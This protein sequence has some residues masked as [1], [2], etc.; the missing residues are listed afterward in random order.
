[1]DRGY[2][3]P[4]LHDL[5]VRGYVRDLLRG[6]AMASLDHVNE[7]VVVQRRAQGCSRRRWSLRSTAITTTRMI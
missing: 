3:G 6:Y 4:Y 2:R 7:C 5:D 1:M